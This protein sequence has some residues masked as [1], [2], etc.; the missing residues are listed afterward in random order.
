[1]LSNFVRIR[2]QNGAAW[3]FLH[4]FIYT[5]AVPVFFI[6]AIFHNIVLLRNP[7]RHFALATGF[8]A[9]VG[10]LWT[11]MPTIIRNKPH[12]YKVL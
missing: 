10:K 5:I 3:Y 7:F 8:T 11:Y 4:L 6:F 12:F 1:M 9:N 2:K